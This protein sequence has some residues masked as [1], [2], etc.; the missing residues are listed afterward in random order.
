MGELNWIPTS[1][2]YSAAVKA[3]NFVFLSGHRGFGDVFVTQFNDAFS[4][5]EKT[6]AEF[7]LPLANLVQVNVRL[8]HIE[9]LPEMERLFRQYFGKDLYPAGMTSSTGLLMTIPFFLSAVS[10]VE[11]R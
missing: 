9:D 5:L 6:L 1:W 11:R 3:G 4:R 2:S 10:P 7:D 8:E